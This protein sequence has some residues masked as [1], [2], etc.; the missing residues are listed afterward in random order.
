MKNSNQEFPDELITCLLH[1]S[2][3]ELS[4]DEITLAAGYFTEEE[5]QLLHQ[6][7]HLHPS[8]TSSPKERLMQA[9]DQHHARSLRLSNGWKIAAMLLLFGVVALQVIILNQHKTNE[10]V[11]QI[12]RDTIWLKQQATIIPAHQYDT[13]YINSNTKS[14]SN[15]PKNANTYTPRASDKQIKS[16]QPDVY[17]VPIDEWK[18]ASLTRRKNN[19]KSDTTLQLLSFV[20]L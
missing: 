14:V 20:T 6:A 13:V 3:N 8:I 12:I 5:Y 18:D 15:R 4:K 1:K 19:I 17:V 2:W 10:M 9:F 7:M 16:L 11:T